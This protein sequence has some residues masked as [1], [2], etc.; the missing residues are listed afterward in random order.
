M[1]IGTFEAIKRSP[2][3]V[4]NYFVRPISEKA[5]AEGLLSHA[6]EHTTLLSD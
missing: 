2:F 6:S 3:S 1:P 5:S 4:G